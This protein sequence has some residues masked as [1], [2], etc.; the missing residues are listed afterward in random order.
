MEEIDLSGMELTTLYYGQYFTSCK[1][2][3]LSNNELSNNVFTPLLLGVKDLVVGDSS[4]DA[5]IKEL[6]AAFP[7]QMEIS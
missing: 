1:K 3:N 4:I 6:I 2:I 5:D 7:L